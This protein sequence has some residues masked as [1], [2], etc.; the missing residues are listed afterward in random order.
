LLR[1]SGIDPTFKIP[2]DYYLEI[3]N[4]LKFEKLYVS[5]DHPN[6][7]QNLLSKITKYNPIIFDLPILELFKIITTK[8][9]II[10]CQGTFSF[11]ACWLS[12]AE[13]IYWPITTI[14]PNTIGHNFI[15]LNVDDE[16]RYEWVYLN[17]V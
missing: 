2:D 9:T 16:E 4:K 8:K 13:K 10:G 3:L 15:N 6:K 5:I 17:N 11:W 7:H 14:G 1:D 12:N